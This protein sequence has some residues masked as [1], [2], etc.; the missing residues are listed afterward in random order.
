MRI[1]AEGVETQEQVE[2]L[3]SLNCH[4]MQGFWFGHPLAENEASKLF[5]LDN[6][7]EIKTSSSQD[8]EIL[9]ATKLQ[10]EQPESE[11]QIRLDDLGFKEE[12]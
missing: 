7:E 4:N 6:M 10:E 3:R 9:A 8:T 1:V 12:E 11:E 5:E 2:L